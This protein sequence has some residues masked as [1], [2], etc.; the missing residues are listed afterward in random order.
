MTDVDKKKQALAVTLSL[1]GQ[2]RAKAVEIDVE[3]LSDKDGMQIL[4][5]ELDKIFLRDSVDLAYENYTKF[6]KYHREEGQ[7]MSSFIIEFERRYDLCKKSDMSL[8][9]AVLSFKLLD[10]AGLSETDRQL[11]L[12]AAKDLKFVSM[13]SALKRIFGGSSHSDSLVRGDGITIKQN[14][15]YTKGD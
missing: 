2:A 14:E 1:H 3:K 12:T 13:K 11:A 5:G 4:F 7:D 10:S 8:P 6:D 15:E 9:D